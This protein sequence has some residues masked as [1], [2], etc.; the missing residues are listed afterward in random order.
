MIADIAKKQ[1]LWFRYECEVHIK[2][3]EDSHSCTPRGVHE[4][5]CTE[6][7]ES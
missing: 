5:K 1:V 6:I 2:T 4:L 7:K 3:L